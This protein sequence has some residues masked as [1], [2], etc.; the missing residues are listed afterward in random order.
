M[1][2]N[3]TEMLSRTFKFVQIKKTLSVEA[4]AFAHLFCGQFRIEKHLSKN[5]PENQSLPEIH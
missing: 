2:S 4:I 5:K 1:K 3:N